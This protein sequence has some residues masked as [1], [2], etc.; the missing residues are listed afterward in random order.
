VAPQ[1]GSVG[2]TV[3]SSRDQVGRCVHTLQPVPSLFCSGSILN[4]P[5]PNA[6]K[7]DKPDGLVLEDHQYQA[8]DEDDYSAEETG[9]DRMPLEPI[10]IPVHPHTTDYAQSKGSEN[11]YCQ[12]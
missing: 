8:D 12:W 9:S 1:P 10:S 4:K 11:P 7:Y 3:P 6:Y 2:R 5:A